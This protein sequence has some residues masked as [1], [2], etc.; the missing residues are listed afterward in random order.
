MVE[1]EN[2]FGYD[3]KLP[4][5][6]C[7]IFMWLCQDVSALQSKWDF[8]IEIFGKAENTRLLSNLAP[9]SFNIIEESLRNDMTMTICR[10]CDPPI[11]FSKENL[12]LATLVEK[13]NVIEDL[14]ARLIEFQSACK[15]ISRLRNKQVGH[16]DLN[17]KISPR[18][19]PLPGITRTQIEKIIEL[20]SE[21]LKKVEFYYSRGD[22]YFHT[23]SRGG[24]KDLIF[25]LK[26][27]Q[28]YHT[29]A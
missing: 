19:N 11:S 23:I 9:W 6:I 25:W 4:Q 27:G 17:T 18:N 13:C 2:A 10:L 8:Y 15:P 12:S 7:E 21:I 26:A 28:K 29:T 1:K 3:P 20:A 24:A 22:L 14:D 16:N 5:D